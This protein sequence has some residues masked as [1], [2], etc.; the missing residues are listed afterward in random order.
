V[1]KKTKIGFIGFGKMAQAI[2]NR[3]LEQGLLPRKSLWAHDPYA[4]PNRK[5]QWAT[6]NAELARRCNVLILAVKPYD[7]QTA[8]ESCR[9]VIQPNTLM[10]SI[11]AGVTLAKLKKLVPQAHWVRVMPNTPAMIGYGMTGIYFPSGVSIAS[12][13]MVLRI[14]KSVGEVYTVQHEGLLNGVTALSGSGPAFVYRFAMAMIK[15]AQKIG[16]SQPMGQKLVVQTL[17]GAAQMLQREPNPEYLIAQVA[18]K[19]GT[20][21]AGLKVLAQSAALDKILAKTLRAAYQRAIEIAEES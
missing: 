10:I 21:L 16:L 6:S 14:F 13:T 15:G 9:D 8:L 2:A 18:S 17:L 7:I 12:Q 4:K 5:V 20:T 19:R 3:V 11:A 1:K